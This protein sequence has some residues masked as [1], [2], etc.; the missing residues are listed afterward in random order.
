MGIGVV[1]RDEKGSMI[2]A[3]SK[4]RQGTFEPVTGEAIASSML[5]VYVRR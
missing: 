5:Q 2:V 4:S 3:S 1:V